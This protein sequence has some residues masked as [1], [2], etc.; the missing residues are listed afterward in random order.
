MQTDI[1]IDTSQLQ[2]LA[3]RLRT[4]NDKV[5]T[6]ELRNILK[7]AAKPVLTTVKLNTPVRDVYRMDKKTKKLVKTTSGKY[8]TPRGNLKNSMQIFVAKKGI[9][10]HVGARTGGGGAVS[11]TKSGKLQNDGYYNFIVNFGS[12]W[13]RGQYHMDLA[14]KMSLPLA[15]RLATADMK[16]Y[17][18]KV[19]NR[20][21]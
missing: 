4:V 5:K 11:V 7:H 2:S 10:V 12:K 19:I 17:L 15:E 20:A 6:K 1:R 13:Q 9:A 3:A 8:S 21:K 14:E 16:K 18:T